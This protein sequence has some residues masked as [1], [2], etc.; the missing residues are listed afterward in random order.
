[1]FDQALTEP[2]DIDNDRY[3]PSDKKME[4]STHPELDRK[5]ES[6]DRCEMSDRTLTLTIDVTGP[7]SED[8]QALIHASRTEMQRVYDVSECE[9]FAVDDFD[10]PNVLFI[11]ARLNGDAV[12]CVA[13]V[14]CISY[15]EI[16]GF[17]VTPGARKNG[18]GGAL[19]KA[20]FKA[21]RDVGLET[22]RLETGGKLQSAIALYQ[23]YGF[24]SRGPFGTYR[25]NETSV[26]MEWHP[27]FQQASRARTIA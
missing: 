21:G 20:V 27:A 17:F 9:Q 5:C 10:Q 3:A 6:P 1:M 4:A 18:V 2:Q 12:G 8:A 15:G 19:L 24:E 14:D 11:I 23:R 22:I 7:R 25:D 13:L 26:F 16:K